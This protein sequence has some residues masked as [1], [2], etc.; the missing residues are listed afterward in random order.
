MSRKSQPARSLWMANNALS[1]AKSTQAFRKAE[2]RRFINWA[3]DNGYPISSLAD[4]T[5]E[6]VK[7]YL[8]DPTSVASEEGTAG[9]DDELN[10]GRSNS[11]GTKH[12]KLA[13]LRRC[14]AAL[15][16]DP[17]ALGI[18]AKALDL[19][20]RSRHGTKLP[21]PDELFF[22]ALRQ[23]EALGEKG[24]VFTLKLERFLGMRGLEALMSGKVLKQY[25]KANSAQPAKN[26]KLADWRPQHC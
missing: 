26:V 7:A 23:A 12:N 17:D 18:T 14:M 13:T 16:T 4:T 20:P 1:G 24:F 10:S 22:T 3:F 9:L 11:T 8:A 5:P 15:G 6:M 21:I 25:Y 2:G 19:E